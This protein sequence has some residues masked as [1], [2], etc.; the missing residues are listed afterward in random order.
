M[1]MTEKLDV[2]MEERGLSKA[3]LSRDAGIPYMTIVNFYEKGTDNVKRSTLLKLS[4]FFNVTVDYLAV[5]EETRRAYPVVTAITADAPAPA[6]ASTRPR[7]AEICRGAGPLDPVNVICYDEMPHGVR[8]DFTMQFHG[9]AMTRIGIRDG[10]V[11]YVRAQDSVEDHEIAAVILE[12]KLT[13]RRIYKNE[14]Q[15]V[16]MAENPAFAPLVLRS[17]AGARIVGKAVAF[18]GADETDAAQLPDS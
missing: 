14:N 7:I 5:D 12:G 18:L 15:V 1:T 13:L 10:D 17:E 9:N 8:C 16:L 11:I 6:S 3:S 4:R 2:L